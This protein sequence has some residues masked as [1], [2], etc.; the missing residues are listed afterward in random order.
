[1]RCE[2]AKGRRIDA[3]RPGYGYQFADCWRAYAGGGFDGV[4]FVLGDGIGGID[5]DNCRDA[6]GKLFGRGQDVSDQFRASYAEVSPSGTGW[7]A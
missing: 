5:E 1:M 4:G 2:P 6:D 7:K 3:T